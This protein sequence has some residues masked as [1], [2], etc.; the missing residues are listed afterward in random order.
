VTSLDY[1]PVGDTPRLLH[2]R[3]ELGY[4]DRISL[5]MRDEPEAIDAESYARLQRLRTD[6][7]DLVWRNSRSEIL[8]ALAQ[9]REV[10]K[11]AKTKRAIR[12]I[13]RELETLG[14]AVASESGGS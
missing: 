6:R 9:I 4:T 3:S 10:A 5:A 13:E 8:V 11:G 14:R 7:R 12:A 1:K 2:R